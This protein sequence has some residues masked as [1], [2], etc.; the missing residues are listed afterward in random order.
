MKSCECCG[1]VFQPSTRR[2]RFCCT[3]CRNRVWKWHAKRRRRK[4]RACGHC[5][6]EFV[7]IKHPRTMF[8]TVLCKRRESY[9]RHGERANARRVEKY[10]ADAKFR[11]QI[12]ERERDRYRNRL[13]PGSNEWV[14]KMLRRMR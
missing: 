3:V 1:D 8:C 4:P 10:R 13:R 5:G 2:Q 6:G 7:P 9:L 11:R 12:V 14:D